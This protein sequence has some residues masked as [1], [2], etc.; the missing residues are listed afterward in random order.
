MPANSQGPY[1]AKESCCGTWVV[2]D[3][4]LGRWPVTVVRFYP[5]AI[6]SAK[7]SAIASAMKYNAGMNELIE[8]IER[9]EVG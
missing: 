3:P 2:E 1:R 5:H 8:D 7:E 6:F 4:T 9:G